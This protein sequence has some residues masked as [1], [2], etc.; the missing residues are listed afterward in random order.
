MAHV[1]RCD[2][3]RAEPSD[4]IVQLLRLVL[5]QAARGLVEDDDA[6]A[7]AYGNGDLQHLLLAGRKIAD[8]SAGV[9][10]RTDHREHLFRAPPHS[11][12]GEES[13]F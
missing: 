11:G 10:D 3:V 8:P 5:R 4:E 13:S 12:D 7:A 9:H 2:A 6:G 1:D